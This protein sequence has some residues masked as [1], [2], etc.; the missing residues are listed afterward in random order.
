[1]PIVAVIQSVMA[2]RV[3]TTTAPDRAPAAAAVA[4]EPAP[5]HHY[6]EVDLVKMA[7]LATI[8]PDSPATR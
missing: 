7:T 4:Q 1:M 5:R 2:W 8:A 6:A 3:R